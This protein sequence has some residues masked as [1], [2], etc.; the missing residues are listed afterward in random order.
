MY[1]I[2]VTAVRTVRAVV[3]KYVQKQLYYDY[4]VFGRLF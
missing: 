2:H 1:A 3:K 4:P